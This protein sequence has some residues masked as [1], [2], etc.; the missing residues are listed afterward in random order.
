MPQ[1]GITS[2]EVESSGEGGFLEAAEYLF[3]RCAGVGAGVGAGAG[4]G[5]GVGA[6]VRAEVARAEGLDVG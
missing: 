5:T 6:A 4:A 2:Q 1:R 3:M